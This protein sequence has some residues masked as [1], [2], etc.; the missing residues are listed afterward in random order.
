MMASREC[1]AFEGE[2]VGTH[3]V[4]RRFVTWCA[5]DDLIGSIHWGV[6]E[7]E[8]M[9]A[10]MATTAIIGHPG[11]APKQCLLVDARGIERVDVGVMMR[12]V[13]VSRQHL[14]RW[15]KH[16][17]RQAV[18]VPENL[19][20]VLLAGS[21]PV[22][23]PEHPFRF[24]ATVEA[25]LEYLQHPGAAAAHAE[26]SAIA[27]AAKANEQ[28]GERLR[29]VLMAD[30]VN[31]TLTGAATALGMSERSLQRELQVR[32]TSFSNE[33]RRTRV[34]AAA[35]LLRLDPEIKV[36]VVALRVGFSTGSQ[37]ASALRRELGVTPA[38]L[39]DDKK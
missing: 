2:P 34:A 9:E 10:L 27:N 23:G 6:A 20:G 26:M 21:L 33:L 29:A 32:G 30:L 39:R 28:L 3:V 22:M 17:V 19:T 36:E 8:D 14:P 37:L 15:T 18:I 31:V 35:D 4:G 7:S 38:A 13:E 16:V 24:V 1:P 5:A 11:L 25:A 12:F